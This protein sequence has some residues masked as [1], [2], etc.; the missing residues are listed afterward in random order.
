MRPRTLGVLLVLVVGLLAFIWFYERD[1]PSTDERAELARK[2][3]RVESA[4]VVALTLSRGEERVRF[5]REPASLPAD[6]AASEGSA[7]AVWR[8][9]EPLAAL[10][11]QA[12]VAGLIDDLTGLETERTLEEA[13]LADLGLREPRARIALETADE[14]VELLVGSAVPASSKMVVALAGSA[15]AHVVADRIWSELEKPAGEW[16][17]RDLGVASR[18]DIARI[19]LSAGE[20]RVSLGRRDGAYWVE[21]PYTDRADRELVSSLLAELTGLRAESFVDQPPTAPELGAGTVEVVLEGREK[22]WRLELGGPAGESGELTLARVGGQLIETRNELAT[23]LGREPEE[24]RSRAWSGL[25]VY[26]IDRLEVREGESEIVF[27]RDAGDWLRD[28]ARVA[29][30]PVSDLLYALTGVEAA[31]LGSAPP[32]GEPR[33]GFVLS[34]AAGE[35]RET[36]TLYPASGGTSPAR[37][38]GREVTLLLDQGTVADL[39]LKLGEAR[40]AERPAPEDEDALSAIGED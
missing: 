1:L 14:R 24:W 8:L 39:E 34:D 3:V 13:A 16:R 11:D 28:G 17:S 9:R 21:A 32:A 36:L 31:A 19:S 7:A 26:Q 23:A 27:E 33:L 2:V 12:A 20:R 4:E 15:E 40:R 30:A 5:E 38:G 6:E 25:E 37:A 29:Y 22:V 18:D 10:A 35:R